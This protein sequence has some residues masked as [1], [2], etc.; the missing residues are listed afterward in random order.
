MR[1]KNQVEH[2]R[3]SFFV[4]IVN[5]FQPLTILAKKTIHCYAQ[6]GSKYG[7]GQTFS[8]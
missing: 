3:W 6:L 4:K 7:S 8:F 5:G 1:I 2:L